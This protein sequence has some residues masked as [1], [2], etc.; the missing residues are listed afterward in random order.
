MTNA[1]RVMLPQPSLA[2]E[3]LILRPLTLEDAPRFHQLAGR[4]EIA[5]TMVSIPHPCSEQQAKD[6]ITAHTDACAQGKSIIFAIE[7]KA[8]PAHRHGW[9]ARH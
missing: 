1:L 9:V 8:T 2:T 7:S 4:R 5:D 3:R 6:W